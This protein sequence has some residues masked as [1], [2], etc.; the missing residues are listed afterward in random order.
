MKNTA[1]KIIQIA[2]VIALLILAYTP[3]VQAQ[4]DLSENMIEELNLSDEQ[5]EKIK[6]INQSYKQK[7]KEAKAAS[8]DKASLKKELRTLRKQRDQEVRTVL[9]KEQ[10]KTFV[11]NKKKSRR[12]RRKNRKG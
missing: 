11:R 9:N 5:G 8:S 12:T 3:V 6:T 1:H 10:N 4:D 2:S 7:F